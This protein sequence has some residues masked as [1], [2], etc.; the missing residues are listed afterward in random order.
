[1]TKATG[2]Q[3]PMTEKQKRGIRVRCSQLERKLTV[4][5]EDMSQEQARILIWTMDKEIKAM[6]AGERVPPC[7]GAVKP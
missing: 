2:Q 6:E 7:M 3:E 5:W 4:D 1:V